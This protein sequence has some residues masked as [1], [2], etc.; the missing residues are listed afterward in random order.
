ML[1]FPLGLAQLV[2]SMTV[3]TITLWLPTMI[4]A[5]EEAE[6]IRVAGKEMIEVI[7]MRMRRQRQRQRQRLCEGLARE[8][9][10]GEKRQPYLE[11]LE[12]STHKNS[13][14]GL[15]SIKEVEV[16]NRDC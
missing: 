14:R 1:G 13:Q 7:R 15:Q 9:V 8:L 6:R 10:P 11:G 12:E 16:L 4:A 3:R 5:V 2:V